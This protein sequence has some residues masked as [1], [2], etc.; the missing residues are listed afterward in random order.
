M[1]LLRFL[2]DNPLILLGVAVAAFAGWVLSNYSGP[3]ADQP[4]SRSHN[5]DLG[6]MSVEVPIPPPPPPDRPQGPSVVTPE[7]VPQLKPGMTRS[8][9][10]AIIG[11]PP[12][13]LVSP[14]SESEGRMTYTAAYLANLDPGPTPVRGPMPVGRRLPPPPN[15]IPKSMIALEFDASKPGHPLLN[16]HINFPK[17]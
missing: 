4:T 16:V 1:R 3:R 2:R 7:Q 5:L 12:A 14:V 8:E 10:E 15:S 6:T 9:V 13:G 17:F 11:P